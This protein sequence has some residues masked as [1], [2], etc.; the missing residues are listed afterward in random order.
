MGSRLLECAFLAAIALA[1]FHR[2][3]ALAALVAG[4]FVLGTWAD[5][6]FPPEV[7]IWIAAAALV[8]A[9]AHGELGVFLLAA[10]ILLIR[11]ALVLTMLTRLQ[12][13]EEWEEYFGGTRPI[14]AWSRLVVFWHERGT[15]AHTA[16]WIVAIA[17]GVAWPA[18][19]L[20]LAYDW[21]SYWAWP[22]VIASA[23]LLLGWL[24]VGALRAFICAF[25]RHGD[26][27]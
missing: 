8:L 24:A 17:L 15:V 13:I 11:S 21:H 7:G 2:E 9:H 4:G 16:G 19:L 12:P 27:G 1:L 14:R 23:V 22:Y 10:P 6:P 3:W 20:W 18:G 5:L 26:P 25:L